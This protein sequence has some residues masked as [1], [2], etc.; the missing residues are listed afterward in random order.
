[1]LEERGTGRYRKLV[2]AHRR[3]VGAIVLG[4]GNDVAPAVRTAIIRGYEV[5]SALDALRDGRWDAL[6]QLGRQPDGDH[7]S[8]STLGKPGVERARPLARIVIA[9]SP[10]SHAGPAAPIAKAAVV[11]TSAVA[12]SG[13]VMVT[14]SMPRGGSREYGS[15]TWSPPGMCPTLRSRRRQRRARR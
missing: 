2:I 7:L 8:Q 10:S 3:V 6:S 14:E 12:S 11:N 15:K 13:P 4:S 1:M 5:S 9:S